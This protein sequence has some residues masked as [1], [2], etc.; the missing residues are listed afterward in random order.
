MTRAA[1]MNVTV[2]KETECFLIAVEHPETAVF[3]GWESLRWQP[4]DL[5]DQ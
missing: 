2:G 5:V 3:R 1:V 4:P